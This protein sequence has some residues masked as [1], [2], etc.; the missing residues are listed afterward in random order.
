[1]VHEEQFS[2]KDTSFNTRILLRLTMSNRP[3][4]K[5]RYTEYTRQNIVG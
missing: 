2:T 1:L 3:M 5:R 4:T